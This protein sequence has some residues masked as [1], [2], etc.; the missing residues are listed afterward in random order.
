MRGDQ[1]HDRE[2]AVIAQA[3][4]IAFPHAGR[5]ANKRI[6]STAQMRI[7]V[8]KYQVEENVLTLYY[9]GGALVFQGQMSP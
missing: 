2:T 7:E 4:G 9:P 1:P 8:T 5:N 6:S 3:A